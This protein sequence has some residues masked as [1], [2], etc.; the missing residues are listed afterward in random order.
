MFEITFF[1]CLTH[2][3]FKGKANMANWAALFNLGVYAL[4]VILIAVVAGTV[5]WCKYCK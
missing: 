4:V 1:T 2:Q 5:F 3:K